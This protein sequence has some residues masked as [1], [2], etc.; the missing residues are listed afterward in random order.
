[1]TLTI[2][3]P[4]RSIFPVMD[5]MDRMFGTWMNAS[6]NAGAQASSCECGWVPPVD[7]IEH[8]ESI[9]VKAEAPGLEKDSF[10]VLVED[11]VLTVSGEKKV[12]FDENDK[13]RNFHRTERI[14][15]SFSRSF[16]LPNNVD[17]KNVS[18]KYRN[19]VL[20]ITLPKSEEAKAKEIKIDVS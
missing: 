6:A 20:E 2:S 16:T 17:Q 9:V 11:G 12:E 8:K 7:I 1:M 15:G 18:A 4:R 13:D 5:D 19:G 3:R 10:K 14:Y